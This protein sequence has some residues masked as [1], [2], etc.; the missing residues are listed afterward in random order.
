M[1]NLMIIGNDSVDFMKFK[2]NVYKSTNIGEIDKIYC[3]GA[4]GTLDNELVT[5]FAEEAKKEIEYI[6]V[7]DEVNSKKEEVKKVNKKNNKKKNK[8]EET[9]VEEIKEEVVEEAK[10]T[11]SVTLPENLYCLVSF[12]KDEYTNL[13][14][15]K[16][17]EAGILVCEY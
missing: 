5:A 13:Y 15:E 4:A 16:A 7:K 8:V 17:K 2:I 12:R 9:I 11:T 1:R 10:E 6:V 14:I 3:L